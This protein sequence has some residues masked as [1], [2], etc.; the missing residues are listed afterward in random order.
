ME[1]DAAGAGD[2]A[3]AIYTDA[4]VGHDATSAADSTGHRNS[5][6][7]LG[8][9]G[10]S[11]IGQSAASGS[12]G[13]VLA[14]EGVQGFVVIARQVD[15]VGFAAVIVDGQLGRVVTNPF[16]LDVGILIDA[17][18]LLKEAFYL[19]QRIELSR[20]ARS[21]DTRLRGRSHG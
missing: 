4:A 20:G 13:K 6:R 11:A 1:S 18:R 14:E 7:H 15:R 16:E 19:R 21:N 10:R 2:D 3:S 5:G 12:A 9:V 8:G 17:A